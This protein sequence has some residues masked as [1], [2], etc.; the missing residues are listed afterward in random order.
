MLLRPQQMYPALLTFPRRAF[1]RDR[2]STRLNSSHRCI[3]YAVFCLKKKNRFTVAE[4]GKPAFGVLGRRL[5]NE[6]HALLGGRLGGWRCL[7]MLVLHQ[8]HATCSVVRTIASK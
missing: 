7:V 2:K 6:Q 4:L 3:S 5:A 1:H 8:R